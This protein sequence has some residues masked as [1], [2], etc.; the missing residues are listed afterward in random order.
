M[1]SLGVRGTDRMAREVQR[2]SKHG[3][4]SYPVGSSVAGFPI[5]TGSAGSALVRVPYL[6]VLVCRVG[7][8]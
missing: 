2:S 7:G 4:S 1:K 3:R 8:Q 6:A 5:N